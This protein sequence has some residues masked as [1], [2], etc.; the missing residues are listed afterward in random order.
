MSLWC[1]W[2]LARHGRG[3]PAPSAAPQR[4]VVRGLYRLTRNPM[5]LAVLTLIFA[6]ALLFRSTILLGYGL[7]VAAGFQLFVCGDEEPPLR[8]RF[9]RECA[10]YCAQVGRWLPR[11][12]PG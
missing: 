1:I 12:R 3:T 4:L 9:G 2:D 5:Y 11:R 6:W 7:L 10:A 8:A